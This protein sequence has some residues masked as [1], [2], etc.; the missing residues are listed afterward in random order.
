MEDRSPGEEMVS[1]LGID[2]A[3][4]VDADQRVE[5]LRRWHEED[6]AEDEER[7]KKPPE[8]KP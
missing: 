7:K 2:P 4:D 6:A 8:S 1:E 5:L 3:I